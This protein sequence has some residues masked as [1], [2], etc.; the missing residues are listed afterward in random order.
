MVSAFPEEELF[1]PGHS[2]C[3]GCGEPIA[4]RIAMK[5][6]GSDTI[7]CLPTGCLEVFSTQHENSAW[8][9]P[10]IHM[11]FENSPAVASGLEAAMKRLE[12]DTKIVIFAGDGATA[13]IGLGS[14]SGMFER[15]HEVIY[16]CLDNE[17]YMNT[18]VQRSGLTPY[19][20]HTT[21][22][23]AGK[24]SIG[25]SFYKKDIPSIAA[26]HGVPY[27]ATSSIAYPGDLYNKVKKASETG[28]SYIHVHTPCPTGWGFEGS[29]TVE[30]AKL[31]VET[32][33]WVNYEIVEGKVNDAMKVRRR[34]VED[35]LKSQR[36]FRHLF[37]SEE[38]QEVVDAIKQIADNNAKLFD[39]VE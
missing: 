38:G 16:V 2:A 26:A 36:R 20:A 31:A 11:L 19:A 8:K 25:N 4:V 7:V 9:V 10:T 37:K 5:A 35:Y 21:T 32:Y 24:L 14:L 12:R 6:L 39:L 13:D 30:V 34:P 27:V 18:G 28:L 3:P 22:S 15:G 17:A 29:K 23:P 33:L 1:M